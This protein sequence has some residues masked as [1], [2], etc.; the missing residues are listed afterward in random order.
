M[1]NES[2]FVNILWIPTLP[3]G[4]YELRIRAPMT[5]SEFYN[6]ADDRT[7]TLQVSREVLIITI[8]EESGI[9]GYVG[10]VVT[11]DEGNPVEGATVE[12]HWSD[13]TSD[14]DS[15]IT[16]SQG[17]AT[18]ESD[19]VKN[20]PSGTTFTFS[21]DSVSKSGWAYDS[22]ANVETSDSISVP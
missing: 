1:T 4:S 8:D 22:G 3:S 9:D 20:A 16:D 15:G 2:G 10:A 5:E 7:S 13:A 11:D 17:Q 12:G 19:E 6:S 14:V 18:L 21:V